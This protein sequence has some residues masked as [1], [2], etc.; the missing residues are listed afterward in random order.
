MLTYYAHYLPD[1][2]ECSQAH[3]LKMNECHPNA[4]CSNTQGL[5]NCSCNPTFIGNGFECKGMFA[6]SKTS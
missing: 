3:P 5:Y 2:D 6:L 1:I 4:S